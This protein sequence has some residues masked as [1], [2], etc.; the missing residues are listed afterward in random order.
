MGNT[1]FKR[2]LAITKRSTEIR[3]MALF[4][5]LPSVNAQITHADHFRAAFAYVEECFR[6]GTDSYKRLRAISLGASGRHELAGGAFALEQAYMSKRREETF[7]ESHK[8]YIDV[9]VIIEGEESIEVADIAK[10][11]LKED[12][13]PGKDLLAYQMFRAASAL[14]MQAGD[15]AVFFPVDGHISLVV[16]EPDFVRKI[17]VKVPVF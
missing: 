15:V 13:T 5:T 10:L 8:R 1:F 2:S 3:G 14:R 6:K 17:V 11:T 4:G 16:K 12:F 7:F 9:Q